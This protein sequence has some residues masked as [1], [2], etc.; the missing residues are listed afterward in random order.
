MAQPTAPKWVPKGLIAAKQLGLKDVAGLTRV[1]TNDECRKLKKAIGRTA[2]SPS[3]IYQW[4]KKKV[5]AQGVTDDVGEMGKFV[6]QLTN[7]LHPRLMAPIRRFAESHDDAAR[8]L[9]HV[10]GRTLSAKAHKIVAD[11]KERE[12]V[13]QAIR[14]ME[15]RKLRVLKMKPRRR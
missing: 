15:I 6:D 3:A 5:R 8:V 7:I 2:P 13:L 10:P 9:Q 4:F 12:E 1:P 14:E 11:F